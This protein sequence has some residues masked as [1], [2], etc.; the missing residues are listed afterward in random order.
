MLFSV[1]QLCA[2]CIDLFNAGTETTSSTLA[3]SL[4]YMVQYPRVQDEMRQELYRVIG[5]ERLPGIEDAPK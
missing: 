1:E 3:Y 5:N 4:R 2:L